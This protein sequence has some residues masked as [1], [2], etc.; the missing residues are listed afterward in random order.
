VRFGIRRLCADRL[1]PF[2][3]L[4]AE[5]AKRENQRY[6]ESL[7]KSPL[8][9]NTDDANRQ[10]YELPPEFFEKVLGKN[11]KYSSGFWP[12]NCRSLEESETAALEETCE[13]AELKDGQ[14]ILELGCGW[15][16]LSLT[17]AARYPKSSI[18]SISNSAP[19]RKFIEKKAHEKG[20]TNLRVLTRNMIDVTSLET[21]FPPF[22][23]VVSVEMFEHMMNYELLLERIS[24]WLKPDGKL[25]VHIFTHRNFSYPFET[26]G[27]DNWMGKYFFTGGQMPSHGLLREFQK[28][29]SLEKD[30]LWD[31]TH[32][33]RTSR[34]WLENMDRQRN[35]I[36]PVFNQV[37]GAAEAKRWFQ[38]WRIFFM[39]CEVL[40]GYKQGS[41]WGVSHYLF[42][43]KRTS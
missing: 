11:L 30:W 2:R 18:V 20:L 24:R 39:A 33:E 27:D 12:A 9:K 19:Q 8:A 6:V 22:D 29:L 23:R 26:E 41:E 5:E 4:S 42:T 17:M 13:R 1:K 31:G 16:S 28:H 40:F 43:N 36:L 34:A 25:F 21:E 3:R 7:K 15:G 35:D 37:Y 38:R 10:H 32:Y 14:R